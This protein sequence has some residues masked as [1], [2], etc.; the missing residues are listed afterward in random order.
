[1][2]DMQWTIVTWFLIG[3]RRY[4]LFSLS[5]EDFAHRLDGRVRNF[6]TR[7]GARGVRHR[8]NNTPAS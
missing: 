6:G 7:S 3:E 1:M 5:T 2:E 8:L 4:A